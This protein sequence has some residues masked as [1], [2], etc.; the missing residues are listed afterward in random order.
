MK[1]KTEIIEVLKS[2]EID[3][4]KLRITAKLD[5]GT[6]QETNKVLTALGGKWRSSAKAHIFE[7]DIA[8]IIGEIIES[9]EYTDKKKEFQFFPTPDKLAK[10]VIELAEIR[11]G[12][13]VLE[14]SAGRGGIAQFVP[15]CDCIELMD[16]NREYLTTNG[17]NLIWDDFLTFPEDRKYDVIVANPPF[18]NLLDAVHVLKM[19]KH[20]RRRVVAIMS[21]G[22]TFRTDKKAEA[23]KKELERYKHTIIEVPQ[24]EFKESGTMIA[25]VIV[26][27]DL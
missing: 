9:G 17:F 14:P 8:D 7:K 4:N 26:V 10:K 2:A 25:T 27:I 23:F 19:L 16:D 21:Q 20:A 15:G 11:P 6:Y 12:E 24:G 22:W 18:T 3:G 13:T 5:R 1:I